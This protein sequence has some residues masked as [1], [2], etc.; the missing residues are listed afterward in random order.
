MTKVDGN[1]LIS[2]H[3][4]DFYSANDYLKVFLVSRRLGGGAEIGVYMTLGSI[5]SYPPRSRLDN[6]TNTH[7]VP[8][9]HMMTSLFFW[10]NNDV[11]IRSCVPNCFILDN[12]KIGE[13]FEA[14]IKH[15]PHNPF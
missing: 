11:I 3:H 13:G 4:E 10:R 1:F 5:L 2:K 7:H 9:K 14:Q 12:L 8:Q 6:F 15:L